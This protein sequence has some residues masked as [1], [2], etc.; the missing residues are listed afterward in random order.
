MS[1][2]VGGLTDRPEPMN[3]LGLAALKSM[4]LRSTELF[5]EAEAFIGHREARLQAKVAR[6]E[7]AG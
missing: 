3:L 1:A 2:I 5:A 6:R 7:E 4:R